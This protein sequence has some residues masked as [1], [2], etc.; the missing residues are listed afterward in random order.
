MK[1]ADERMPMCTQLSWWDN[2]FHR[3]G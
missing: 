1:L 2:P 3:C